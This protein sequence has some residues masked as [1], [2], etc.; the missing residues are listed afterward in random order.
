MIY[1]GNLTEFE[2]AKQPQVIVSQPTPKPEAEPNQPPSV[3]VKRTAT[4]ELGSKY[5]N[6]RY[7]AV[8]DATGE[9]IRSKPC[10][11]YSWE[12]LSS[13]SARGKLFDFVDTLKKEGFRVRVDG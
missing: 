10:L 7:D 9:V 4:T 12:S 3:T 1:S 8:S 5:T 13:S 11:I 2:E 6:V